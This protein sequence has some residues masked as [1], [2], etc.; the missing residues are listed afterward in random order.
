MYVCVLKNVLDRYHVQT[1]MM[2]M[3]IKKKEV[4]IVV[5]VCVVVCDYC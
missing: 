1:E 2:K 3:L 5:V 4:F